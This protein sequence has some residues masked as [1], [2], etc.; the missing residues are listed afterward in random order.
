MS[1]DDFRLFG[2]GALEGYGEYTLAVA[3]SKEE[4]YDILSENGYNIWKEHIYDYKENSRFGSN[5]EPL[6]GCARETLENEANGLFD[7]DDKS[8]FDYFKINLFRIDDV[9]DLQTN[10]W[11]GEY[12]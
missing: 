12:A 3:K 4:A 11:N 2:C 9:V 10:V 8:L 7:M 5:G 1:K 6:N